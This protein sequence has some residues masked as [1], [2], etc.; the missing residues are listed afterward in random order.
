MARVCG[1]LLGVLGISVVAA[2]GMAV[3]R[4]EPP[5]TVLPLAAGDGAE[6]QRLYEEL[7]K[8]GKLVAETQE[9]RQM[10]AYNLR[11]AE[12]L[13]H[14][15]NHAT[16]A[17]QPGWIKQMADCLCVAAQGGG[18]PA[19]DRLMRLQQQIDAL[20]PG[21]PLAGYVAFRVLQA[22]HNAAAA[23]PGADPAKLQEQWQAQL[24]VYV[25]AYPTAEDSAEALWELGMMNEI[26]GHEAESREFYG[27]LVQGFPEHRHTAVA[28]RAFNRLSL[29]GQPLRLTL[30]LISVENDRFDVP[31]ATTE[32][33][34]T[35]VVV[36]VWASMD[37][38][39]AANF[40]ELRLLIDRQGGSVRLLSINLDPTPQTARDFLKTHPMPGIHVYATGGLEGETANRLGLTT[41]PGVLLLDRAGRVVKVGVELNQVEAEVKKLV[42]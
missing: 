42:R 16:P 39:S 3:V 7:S 28:R 30:P 15:I 12:I 24:I 4:A 17:E 25:K 32:L 33:K 5:R 20:R 40:N 38:G 6:V 41:L 10:A 22:Q 21:T 11:E 37:G 34:G 31:F 29:P 27:Q 1:R 23:A 26:Q 2:A 8:I 9:P 18:G 13:A 14:V 35:P 36:Y 19:Y